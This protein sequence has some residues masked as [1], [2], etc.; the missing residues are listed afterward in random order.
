M[1][2]QLCCGF[3]LATILIL[4]VACGTTEVAPLPD[5]IAGFTIG[6]NFEPDGPEWRK[7]DYGDTAVWQKQ[8]G[9]DA[10]QIA[11]GKDGKIKI[12]TLNLFLFDKSTG[13]GDESLIKKY[14]D[15][16]WNYKQTYK[17]LAAGKDKAGNQVFVND[18]LALTVNI[19]QE[20]E[21]GPTRYVK[22]IK[23]RAV[24]DEYTN[25]Q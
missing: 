14:Q 5:S 19:Y 1:S 18:K 8:Q 22:T 3:A 9:Q 16:I 6:Q 10:M 12:I 21:N 17:A 20:S 15:E 24:Y 2:K 11:C 25:Q 13:E 4:A 7:T 23:T